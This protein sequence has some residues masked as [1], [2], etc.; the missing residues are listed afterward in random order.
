[1]NTILA[2]IIGFVLVI[3]IGFSLLR[4]KNKSIKK[5]YGTIYPIFILAALLIG[6]GYKLIEFPINEMGF[7]GILFI[8]LILY[9]IY[10]IYNYFN[11]KMD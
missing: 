4:K 2:F 6:F 5:Y 3:F 11:K 8:I 1:M 9:F 10:M 7:T